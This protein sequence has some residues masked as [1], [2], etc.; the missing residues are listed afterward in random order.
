MRD[1]TGGRHDGPVIRSARPEDAAALDD[2]C[3]RTALAGEDATGLLPDDHL[4]CDV[5]E[6]PY[7]ELEPDL[8][9]VVDD[10]DAGVVGYVIGTADSTAFARRFRT[11]WL[12]RA[13]LRHPPGPRPEAREDELVR[14]LHDPERGLRPELAGYPGHLHID[15]LP[16]AQGRGWGR[17]L[18][19]TFVAAVR[20]RGVP[21][22][23]LGHAP[24][25][26]RAAAFYAH[27]G[28]QPVPGLDH[29]L[30]LAT[31]APL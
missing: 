12:P 1:T 13:G 28:F 27:L 18:I 3:I 16:A 7:L 4:W 29:H 24:E 10:P 31:D 15:L 11:E 2:I 30:W 26:A 17:R 25:N 8:A 5:Y 14:A 23:H 21:A 9:F 22:V 19:A 6:R 20:E